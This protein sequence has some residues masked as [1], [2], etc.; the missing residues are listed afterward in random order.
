MIV[1]FKMYSTQWL[2]S[3]GIMAAIGG[4]FSSR[5]QELDKQKY[6]KSYTAELS[7]K[8]LGADVLKSKHRWV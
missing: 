1:K 8:S 6:A 2:F 4:I 3:P 5:C 7:T